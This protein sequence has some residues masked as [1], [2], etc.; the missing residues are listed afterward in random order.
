MM[1]DTMEFRTGLYDAMA[2]LNAEFRSHEGWLLAERFGGV[3]EDETV[4]ARTAVALFDASANGKIIIHGREAEAVAAALGAPPLAINAGAALPGGVEVYRLR[5][6]QFY[7]STRPGDPTGSLDALD[8]AAAAP[9]VFVTVTDVTHGRSQL[10]LFG[11][12]VP[13]LLSRLCGLDFHPAAF[14]NHTAKQTSVAKTTQLVVRHNA[15][16][17]PSYSLIGGRSLSEYLWN[18]VL[19]AGRDLGLRPM[20]WRAAESLVSSIAE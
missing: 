20:G 6:D 9:G 1:N 15:G 17:I 2:K 5:A 18:T 19:E 10:R 11:P 3:D 4:A 7:V 12:A 13:R 8:E 14:P 16:D